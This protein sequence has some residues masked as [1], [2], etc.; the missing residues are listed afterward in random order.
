[1]KSNYLN[2][3]KHALLFTIILAAAGYIVYYFLPEFYTPVFP[4][5][6]LFFL[7]VS[8]IVHYLLIKAIQKRPA[9][10]I[11]QFMLTTFLKLLFYIIVLVIYSLI[12]RD[13]AVI[14]IVTYFLLY[15]FFTV[16]EMVSILKFNKQNLNLNSDK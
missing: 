1:M 13:D 10:F 3:L 16:F 14:F 5:L 2:Y 9:K 15:L 12:N 6:L 8:L 4:F 11:N 7:S